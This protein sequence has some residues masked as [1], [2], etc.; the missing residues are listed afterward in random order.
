MTE[1]KGKKIEEIINNFAPNKRLLT[2]KKYTIFV[3]L[4]KNLKSFIMFFVWFNNITYQPNSLFNV[5][6]YLFRLIL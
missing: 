5:F 6:F 4:S 2:H 3:L 1:P